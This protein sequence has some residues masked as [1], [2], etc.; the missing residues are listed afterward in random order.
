MSLLLLLNGNRTDEATPTPPTPPVPTPE[1]STGNG[2]G[3]LNGAQPRRR[4]PFLAMSD[5]EP[6]DEEYILL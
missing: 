2:G 6:D 1:P 4:L 3:F 5:Y